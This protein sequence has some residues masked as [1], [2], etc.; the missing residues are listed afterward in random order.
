M[1]P[2]LALLLGLGMVYRLSIFNI[3]VANRNVL[4]HHLT[5]IRNN[6]QGQIRHSNTQ[7]M[8]AQQTTILQSCYSAATQKQ[9]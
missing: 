5:E 1:R 7:L 6:A 8:T 4:N 3:T 2:C 9:I